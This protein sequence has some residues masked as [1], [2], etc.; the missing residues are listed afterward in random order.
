MDQLV[1]YMSHMS[2]KHLHMRIG[3]ITQ[4]KEESYQRVKKQY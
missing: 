3:E 4:E 2:N 1:E